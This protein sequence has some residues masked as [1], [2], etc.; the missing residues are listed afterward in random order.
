MQR[1][2]R[3]LAALALACVAACGNDAPPAPR[4]EV[5]VRGE[6]VRLPQ[7]S[8]ALKRIV[9]ATPAEA[10]AYTVRFPARLT[11]D[12]DHT[13]RITAPLAGRIDRILAAPGDAVKANQPLAYL[14][15][16]ELG[17]AQAEA[18]RA[19]ADLAQAQK[20]YAR[21]SDL[22]HEG[23]IAAK[24]AEQ[25]ATDV[26]RARAEAARA[27]ARLRAL[28]S[29][30]TVDQRLALRS[31]IAGVVV[32]RNLNPGMESRPDQPAPPMFVVS[33]PSYLWCLID[34]PERAAADF[35][36]GGK[37]TVRSS[38]WPSD[39]FEATI[40]H[41]GDALDPATRTL[42][43]R[44][45]LRNRERKLKAEM[46]VTVELTRVPS[47]ALDIPAAA[48][49]LSDGAQHAFVKSGAGEF[50]RRRIRAAPSREDHFTVSEG[51]GIDDAVV[52][53]GALYLQQL[54][55]AAKLP[56]KN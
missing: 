50:T 34:A 13:S 55:D 18:A 41:I 38:A 16:P 49:F 8:G 1:L 36:R 9:T 19:Q 23:I 7:D 48:V 47:G 26:E 43:V 54:M 46:F 2:L 22:A 45:H 6:V 31:P 25:A 51:L 53:D 30:A 5:V 35:A 52:I 20:T 37:V 42:K 27:A 21:A 28:G 32:E 12:E 14:A 10:Q 24:E 39:A 11:W 56:V 15:S 40:D 44:A 4:D 17:T 3:A 33:D 29:A